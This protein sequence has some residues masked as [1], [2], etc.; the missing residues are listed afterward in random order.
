[1]HTNNL[2][3]LKFIGK[4]LKNFYFLLGGFIF[5]LFEIQKSRNISENFENLENFLE[6]LKSDGACRCLDPANNQIGGH[7]SMFWLKNN[8]LFFGVLDLTDKYFF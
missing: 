1:M 8:K 6:F 3:F 7:W 4:N 5:R 2:L